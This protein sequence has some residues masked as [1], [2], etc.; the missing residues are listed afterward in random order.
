VEG[1]SSRTV[2]MGRER[3]ELD[4]QALQ[5]A[6]DTYDEVILQGRFNIGTSTIDINRS[7]TLRG[8]GRTNDIPD[9]KIYKRGWSFPFLSQEFMFD[10]RG[11]GIDVTI[12]NIHV[13]DFNGTCI[14]TRQGNSVTI[15]RNR[16]TLLS[17][18]GRGLSFGPWG[19]HVVG[20]TSGGESPSRGSSPGGVVIEENYLDFALSFARGGFTTS[21]GLER[22][23]DYRPDL[24]NHETP[25]CV[26]MLLSRNLGKVIVRNNTVR[27]MN[28]RGIMAMDNWESAE[29]EI[30]DNTV[31]SEVFGAYP[32]N[33]P[34]SGVGI[35]V[36]SAWSEPRSGGRVEVNGNRINCD[37]V[38]YC[39][40]A[41]HGPAMYQ[42]GVGKL[43]Q[44]V[45][46]DN[47]IKLKEGSFGIQIRR[48]DS[49]EVSDNRI[50]GEA[51]YGLQVTGSEDRQGIDL[52]A[53]E[54]K[55]EDNDME[56]LAIK[57]PD[58]YSDAHVDGRMFTGSG[59]KSATAHIWLNN[60]SKNNVIKVKAD[61][62][63]IDE[64]EDNNVI[65]ES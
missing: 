16:I 32:Y 59:E 15:R 42:E 38:N 2:V 18:L 54:N 25:I 5:D 1:S 12:E 60:Y 22:E 4:A 50:T 26:G 57:E 7:V 10:I 9:T 43:E 3:P 56:G 21:K 53:K 51:Y 62:T 13:E 37:K 65:F 39:G 47:E 34:M 35:L 48:S 29:I 30:T 24:K 11:E 58:E 20:I 55:F 27:N 28:A 44:V 46:R 36:Q 19:D 31:L 52:S 45:I 23:P 14:N 61:E 63:V 41:V 64:G 49:T 17:G 8:E 33:N 6:L 40:I